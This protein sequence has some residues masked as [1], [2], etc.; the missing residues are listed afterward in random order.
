MQPSSRFWHG[1]L[2]SMTHIPNLYTIVHRLELARSPHITGDWTIMLHVRH[3]EGL[4][5]LG[6]LAAIYPKEMYRI[7]FR[8]TDQTLTKGERRSQ[9]PN[10]HS[11]Q[12][13]AERIPY[14]RGCTKVNLCWNWT[15]LGALLLVKVTSAPHTCQ[16]L[17]HNSPSR[18]VAKKPIAVR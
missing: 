6:Q 13:T 9:L 18:K 11:F 14:I 16:I 3:K 12:L 17:L 10:P 5:L 8:A 1:S 4:V 7:A 15:Y 2:S